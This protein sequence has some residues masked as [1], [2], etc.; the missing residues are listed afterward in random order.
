MD[1]SKRGVLDDGTRY[2]IVAL[3]LFGFGG[4]FRF[5]NIKCLIYSNGI[6]SSCDKE[7]L[8]YDYLPATSR[9][10]EIIMWLM[11]SIC[12]YLP[13]FSILTFRFLFPALSLFLSF[14]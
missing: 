3:S 13:S 9:R 7:W 10:K 6:L 2:Q 8:D 14:Q 4:V 5:G 11:L 1:T 12:F